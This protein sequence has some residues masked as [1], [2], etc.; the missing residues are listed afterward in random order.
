MSGGG[1]G[2]GYDPI[3]MIIE[4][5]ERKWPNKDVTVPEAVEFIIEQINMHSQGQLP[6]EALEQI[7]GML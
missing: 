4:E 5:L 7:R 3:Q 6:G 1:A 2:D